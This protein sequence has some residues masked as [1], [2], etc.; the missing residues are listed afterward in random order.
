L[1]P[2]SITF[3]LLYS[4]GNHFHKGYLVAIL[5][6]CFILLHLSFLYQWSLLVM[7]RKKP[8]PK[9]LAPWT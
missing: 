9:C 1:A 6:S 8:Q 2:L 7:S 3:W 5:P 4:R